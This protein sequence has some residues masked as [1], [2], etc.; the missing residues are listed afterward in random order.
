MDRLTAWP[1]R[2]LLRLGLLLWV[3]SVL[4]V[5]ACLIEPSVVDPTGCELAPGSSVFGDPTRSWL[6]PGTTC[7]YDLSGFGLPEHVV[8]RPSPARLVVVVLAV[9]GLPLLHHLRRLLR[10][11][12]VLDG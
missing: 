2:R 1:G 12:A 8:I 6:P 11:P 3:A 7:T 10:H 5:V 4:Y 9:L